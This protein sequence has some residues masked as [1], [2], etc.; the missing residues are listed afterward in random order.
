MDLSAA[1]RMV[2][3]LAVEASKA[4]SFS[5]AAQ[6]G[7]MQVLD[8]STGTIQY[9]DTPSLPLVAGVSGIDDL[10]T[11]FDAEGKPEGASI[12]VEPKRVV[13]FLDRKRIAKVAMGLNMHPAMSSL[14]E[15]EELSPKDL[16]RKLRVDLFDTIV[17]PADFPEV[18]S[19]LKFQVTQTNESVLRKGDESIGNNLR[20][21]VTGESEL[22]ESVTFTFAVFPELDGLDT[23]EAVQCA[24]LTSP[25]DGTISVVP[26][27]GQVEKAVLS[28]LNVIVADLCR[29]I[30]VHVV[31]GSC[32]D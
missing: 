30:P 21:Q 7:R 6:K 14:V 32:I 26:Y 20:A 10:V 24:V 13:M 5:F 9:I 31:C 29:R 22:P 17:S 12:W 8:S 15:L 19:V 18:M 16:H 3:D 11:V 28:A 1:I 23:R 4:K 27:P 2:G 25:A